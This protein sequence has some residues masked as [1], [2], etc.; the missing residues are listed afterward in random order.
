MRFSRLLAWTALLAFLGA[1]AAA[2][3]EQQGPP[4]MPKPGPEHEL[5]KMDVGTWD[6]VVEFT[7]GPGAPPMTSK[8][9]EV[10]TLG[11]GG[12]CVITDFKA[13]MMPG[14]SFEGHGLTTWDVVKKKY[15]GSWTDSMSQGLAITEMTWD[16]A[17]KKFSGWMEGPDMTGKVSKTRSVAEHRPDGTR[18][19]TA[20]APGPD[21]KEAQVLRITYTRRK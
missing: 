4:P 2:R 9:V 11:C 17:A 14:T 6:A 3:A 13:E 16:P 7:P 8:G 15:V 18:V 12:L 10:N 1:P 21:G 5:F 20:F 19:M